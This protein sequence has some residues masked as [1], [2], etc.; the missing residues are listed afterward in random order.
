H[1]SQ[2]N[3]DLSSHSLRMGNRDR[4]IENLRNDIALLRKQHETDRETA[5]RA[6]MARPVQSDDSDSA[7]I[8]A[9]PVKQTGYPALYFPNPTSDGYFLA[10]NGRNT[11]TEGASIYKFTLSSPSEATFE[12]CE[13][14]SSVKIALN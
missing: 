1:D 14:T 13:D 10:D 7:G 9:N 2:T 5:E 3:I 4:E 11:F 8:D 12:Y 6:L